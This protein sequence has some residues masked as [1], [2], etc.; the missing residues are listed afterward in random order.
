[1][2]LRRDNACANVLCSPCFE[3][4]SVGMDRRHHKLEQARGAV[5]AT[6]FSTLVFCWVLALGVVGC[7]GNNADPPR[8]PEEREPTTLDLDG[9]FRAEATVRPQTIHRDKS[10]I[11]LVSEDGAALEL[12]SL[13]VRA[14]LERPLAF[15]EL[16]MEFANPEGRPLD[17][18]LS[19]A[20][21]PGARVTRFA[22]NRK[23]HWEDAE[24]VPRHE[25]YQNLVKERH[26]PALVS[27]RAGEQFRARVFPV[28]A[29]GSTRI[30]VSYLHEIGAGAQT[31]RV[32]LAGLQSEL[33]FMM[34]RIHGSGLKTVHGAG[35]IQRQRRDG[36]I[37]I[38]RERNVMPDKDVVVEY[39]DNSPLG[40][41]YDNMF[42]ARFSP[43]HHDHNA[44]VESLTILFDTSAS[45]AL[46][47]PRHVK[48][49]GEV[50]SALRSRTPNDFRLRIVAFDQTAQTVFNGKL[51]RFGEDQLKELRRR[52]P[53]GASDLAGA[54]RFVSS[55]SQKKF[56]RV[57][58]M[59]DGVVTGGATEV[60]ALEREVKKLRRNG[61]SRLDVMVEGGLHDQ[62]LLGKLVSRHLARS[63]LVMPPGT[64]PD[65]A[66][67]KM[68][69]SVTDGINVRIPDSIWVYPQQLSGVQHGDEVVVFAEYEEGDEASKV[70]VTL[71]GPIKQTQNLDV[72]QARE[73][74]LAAAWNAA[75]VQHIDRSYRECLSTGIELC[76][77]FRDR[78]LDIST[79]HRVLNDYTALVM[80]ADDDQH[81]RFGLDTQTPVSLLTVAGEGLRA[82]MRL[83]IESADAVA[84]GQRRR[85]PVRTH[86][87]STDFRLQERPWDDVLRAR[88]A[89]TQ[90]LPASEVVADGPAAV[91]R[92]E[93]LK[94]VTGA[95][96]VSQVVERLSPNR[97]DERAAP[98]PSTKPTRSVG[99]VRRPDEA[100][101]GML[102]SV[103][104]YLEWGK[105]DNALR[106]ARDWRDAEPDNVVALVALGRALEANDRRQL[107]SRAYGSIV[108]LY[109]SR[110]DMRRFAAQQLEGL[111]M[112]ASWLVIDSYARALELR[113]DDPSAFRMLAYALLKAEY[114]QAA[115]DTLV[116]GLAWA[117]ADKRRKGVTRILAEDLGLFA[118]TWLKHRPGDRDL[119]ER[120]LDVHNISLPTGPSVR[121][122]LSWETA[123]SDV[124]LHIRDG[125]GWHAY[126]KN[127]SLESGGHLYGDIKDGIGLEAF[128]I[129]GEPTAYPYN[130]Q[131]EYFTNGPMGFG[132]GKVQIVEHDGD[133]GL[134]FDERPYIVTRDRAYV[135]L[136]FV[137]GK[138][139]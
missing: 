102:L 76:P 139:L 74:L 38:H 16:E 122:V 1:M 61:V 10:P 30:I 22:V 90:A 69:R 84:V 5:R 11:S 128:V 119:I 36:D 134:T 67:R 120:N 85:L 35:R 81:A 58:L 129:D 123:A 64:G 109:P 41:R 57:L 88:A 127:P 33:D 107:A 25:A 99:P 94:P 51:S 137:T 7:T 131:V 59:T 96:A 39:A 45:Q 114:Y 68:L 136:G 42:V 104:K 60:A 28:E 73:P 23:G 113:S 55:R 70:K 65:L 49:L 56:K 4:G 106:L 24:V 130:V 95:Q 6:R 3:H 2:Q 91:V 9:T 48:R 125:G 47:Y 54:L 43:V 133:G 26:D 82:Q 17:A 124:D 117:R 98:E 31:Y 86:A 46:D 108:D 8:S 105:N 37:Y 79:R 138:S 52:R 21:P 63:G 40:L 93:R 116:H 19:V 18:R 13:L 66:V 83:P 62:A 44:P 101:D 75:K 87:V 97:S 132:M 32:P 121:F 100:Y 111:G 135:D 72:I 20:I 77:K 14:D 34:I 15:T 103:M 80:L 92:P 29:H 118:A 112:G 115:F 126:H 50:V 89:A 78:I 71:D 53:L 27:A 110:P 12:R